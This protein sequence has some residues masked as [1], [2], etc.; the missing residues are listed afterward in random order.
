M[1]RLLPLLL[2]A[3]LGCPTKASRTSGDTPAPPAA[4]ADLAPDIDGIAAQLIDGRYAPGI[5]VG[6]IRGDERWVK[7]YGQVG[8]EDEQVPDGDT[9]FEIGSVTKVFTALLAADAEARGEL[10]LDWELRSFLPPEVTTPRHDRGPIRLR[11]LATHTS[12]LP[13]MPSNF[14]PADPDNPFADYDADRLYS[15]L[16]EHALARAPGEAYAYSNVGAGLLG[17]AVA[18]SLQSTWADALASRILAPLGLD[19]TTPS[20]APGL[21][22][23]VGHDGA[24]RPVPSWDLDVL[25]GAGDLT[26]TANDM[27]DFLGAQLAPPPGSLGRAIRTSHEDQRIDGPVRMGL[28]WHLGLGGAANDALR[29][30]NGQTAG[31]HSII[32]FDPEQGFGVVVLANQGSG[33]IDA[34][35]AAIVL[36]LRGQPWALDLPATFDVTPEDLSMLE[37]EY[38]LSLFFVLTVRA[39]GDQL[40]VQATGQPEFPVF[41]TAEDT[42]LYRVVD[43]KLVFERDPKTGRGTKLVLHQNGGKS[44]ANRVD[45]PTPEGSSPD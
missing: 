44:T 5:V 40:F 9:V 4:L 7:G 19:A 37:G 10:T 45:V 25:A 8:P 31:F 29:W 16:S 33:V 20:A 38:V 12:G 24:S 23:A 42:F 6:I 11:H 1:R 14:E 22:A 32:G 21:V 41:A 13:R 17:H 18:R 27:L 34:F 36:M 26:S 43:A 28:G 39:E 2:V 15:F 35:G 3:A 30:H